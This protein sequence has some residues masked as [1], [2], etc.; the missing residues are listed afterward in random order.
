[1]VQNSSTQPGAR[2]LAPEVLARISSLELVARSVVK[3][4]AWRQFWRRGKQMKKTFCVIAWLHLLLFGIGYAQVKPDGEK[5]KLAGAVQTMRTEFSSLSDEYGNRR[6][7]P[8]TELSLYTFDT[9]GNN[10]EILHHEKNGPVSSRTVTVYNTAG[11]KTESTTYKGKDKL[12]AKTVYKLDEKGRVAEVAK[13]DEK[14]AL[15]SRTVSTYDEAGRCIQQQREEKGEPASTVNYKYDASGRLLEFAATSSSGDLLSKTVYAYAA[16][17]IRI[18]RTVYEDKKVA[19]KIIR[20]NNRQ[21]HKTEIGFYRADNTISWKWS[22]VYDE[23]GLVTGEE[24]ASE[25]LYSK[26]DYAY[27]IDAQGNWTKQTKSRWYRVAGKPTPIPVEAFYRT[28][29]Y[30]PQPYAPSKAM[31]NVAEETSTYILTGGVLQ[32]EAIKRVEPVYPPAAKFSRIS[33][34]VIIEA[35]V[36]EEGNVINAHTVSGPDLLRG[37]SEAAIKEWKFKPTLS[38][39]MPTKIIGTVTFNFHL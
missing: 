21:N 13:Y 17:V 35:T 36:D 9:M 15:L 10:T 6:N 11:L 3:G 33:G 2:S 19:Q 25:T 28:I 34:S 23:R 30:F 14:N 39:G 38:N 16:D 29:T 4:F 12:S 37:A 26:Y 31:A 7:G 20:I 22:F 18:E 5:E 1:M 8:R 27:E 32:G 24:F